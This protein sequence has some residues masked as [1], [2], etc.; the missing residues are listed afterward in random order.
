MTSED[1]ITALR[2]LAEEASECTRCPLHEGR[3]HVVFGDGNPRADLMFIGEGPGRHEDEQGLPFVGRSGQLLST[4]LERVGLSRTDV[5]IANVVKCRPPGNRDPR[6]DE[7]AACK[8]YLAEQIR[9]ID[10][11]AVVTLGNFSTKLL[12]KTETGITRMRGRAYPWWNRH[13]VPTFH[14][15][16][17]LRNGPRV[18]EEMVTD[19]QLAT[20]IIA[21]R[22]SA[23]DG[24]TAR[25]PEQTALFS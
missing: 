4:L 22:P 16:A 2:M 11:A 5:Y 7:I 24:E 9:L 23:P 14:P 19:L 21:E 3:T 15:A 8:S 25:E 1:R 10:P 12:L 17:A 18:V 13:V 20:R 6:P